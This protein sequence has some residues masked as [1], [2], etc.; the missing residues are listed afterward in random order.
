MPAKSTAKKLVSGEPEPGPTPPAPGW[1]APVFVVLG[2]GL[3]PWTVLLAMTLPARHG[4]HHY[5]VAWTGFDVA[6]AGALAATGIGA[7]RR[8][9]WLQ[10]AAAVA[11][12]LL[13]CDA[14]F[15]VLS[16]TS[17]H[18]VLTSVSLALLV[19]LPLALACL[20]VARHA[21][22]AADRAHRY[23]RRPRRARAS[24]S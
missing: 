23:A 21:E 11:A 20:F 14:W 18:E 4:T 19:E 6:L 5:G 22:E 8:A 2:L 10:S 16:S 17:Q 1:V 15:D 7:F 9:A 24:R 3:I 12:T 13:V